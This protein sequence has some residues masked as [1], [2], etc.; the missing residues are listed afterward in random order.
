[1][2]I[3]E[4]ECPQ[5]PL[6]FEELVFTPTETPPCPKCGSIHTKRLMSACR[7]KSGGGGGDH[8]YAPPAPSSSGGG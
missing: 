8:G 4:F 5:C 3:Y 6:E 2:P 1:M 7:H